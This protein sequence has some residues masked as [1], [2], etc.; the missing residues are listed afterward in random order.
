MPISEAAAEI[1]RRDLPFHSVEESD[2]GRWY[3]IDGQRLMSVTTAFNAIA[4]RGLI[5]WAAGLTAEQAF[6]DLP[7]LV[8]ASRRPL[9][10]NTWSRCH[11]DGNESCEKCPC[12]VCRLCVQKW[13]ADRHER[14]SA[15]RADEGT[16]VH[17]VAEWWSFHG[18]IRDHDTD[19]APYV[20][21]F[22]EYTEDYGLTPDDVLLAEALLIH[23]DIGAAGQTDG[24]TRYHAERTEA[25][26]KLVSRILTKR[27]EPVSWK[28][29]AKRKLTVDLIDDYKTREDDKP[30]F[31]PENALQLSGYRHFPTIRVK[32]SDEEAPMIPVDGGVIIQL[33]PDGY[34]LRPVLCDQGVYERGFLPAL[35]LYR[36]LTEEGPASVSSH[37]FVLPE[38]LAARARKAAK[39]QATAQSTPPAA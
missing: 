2:D 11:H 15:R 37:T 3:I 24:V 32:N 19:I 33:R 5:P 39:E 9:C 17:D 1:F 29:A 31:Y 4:K 23:R 35:N 16:R 27:G 18:V 30:K 13:L 22:V 25:A 10:D 28:Q 34:A 20:K 6:A 14:E 36:W 21:S 7:M 26:A 12:R 38:T 8:S